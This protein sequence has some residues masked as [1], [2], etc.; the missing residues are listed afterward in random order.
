VQGNCRFEITINT[1]VKGKGGYDVTR[2]IRVCEDEVMIITC[3]ADHK[4]QIVHANYGRT[5][6]SVCRGALIQNETCI[7]PESV[8]IVKSR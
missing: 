6:K 3:P 8:D 7:V 2:I 1:I 4:I 5:D